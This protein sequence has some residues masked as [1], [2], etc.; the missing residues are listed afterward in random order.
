MAEGAI[1][2]SKIV[3][4]TSNGI[5]STN[6]LTF[7]EEHVMNITPQFMPN[8]FQGLGFLQKAKWRNLVFTFD[9]D[10][11]GFNASYAITAVNTAIGTSLIV[12]FIVLDGAGTTE[13]WTY[14]IAKSF[15]SKRDGGRIEDGAPRNTVEFSVLMYGTKLIA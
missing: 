9:S 4:V 13:T 8:T 7:R 11:D 1:K 6:V 2:L 10:T 3:S 15:V 14:Q 12:S 5:V